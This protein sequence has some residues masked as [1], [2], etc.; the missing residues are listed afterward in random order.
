[1]LS[2]AGINVSTDGGT[3]WAKP[4]TATPPDGFCADPRTREQPAAFGI[5][6]SD[7]NA[8]N[9]YIGTNCGLAISGDRGVT[10]HFVNP[11]LDQ[12]RSVWDVVVHHGA[13]VDICGDDGHARSTDG[14]TTWTSSNRLPGG[15]C[16]IAAAPFEA[17]VLFAVVG[18]TIYE[19]LNSGSTWTNSYANPR[20]QGRIP[21]IATNRR[22]GGAY[23]LWFGDVQLH[24]LGCATPIPPASG[25]AARC[26][27]ASAWIGPFT[28]S[29]G[30]HDDM[31]AILFDPA[32]EADACPLLMSSDGGVYFNTR[33]TSPECH[34]PRWDQPNATPQA[35]WNWAMAGA[36][37]SGTVP[38]DLYFGDQDTGSFGTTDAGATPPTW[39]NADCCD[40]FDVA[41][42]ISTRRLYC[43]LLQRGTGDPHAHPKFRHD[44]RR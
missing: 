44:R 15:T 37:R 23:D 43:V 2:R 32:A 39:N 6:V 5:A 25:G 26:Q 22:A 14:G 13:I 7:I 21:F 18:T 12:A 10:W 9:V 20:P 24:R 38:E 30:G 1:M 42:Q 33:A 11:T 36:P 4:P 3:T 31:G 28:R 29:A 41:A 16:S 19:S 40:V 34:D 35:V 8:N 17:H 27:P